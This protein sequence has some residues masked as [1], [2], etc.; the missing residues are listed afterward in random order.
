MSVRRGRRNDC[1]VHTPFANSVL[2]IL[3]KLI[4]VFISLKDYIQILLV[5]LTVNANAHPHT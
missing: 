4:L 5:F 2:N 3:S 1:F